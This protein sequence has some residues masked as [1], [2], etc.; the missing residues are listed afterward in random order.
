[1]WSDTAVFD[2]TDITDGGQAGS[3][4]ALAMGL[5]AEAGSTGRMTKAK[6]ERLGACTE[7]I[8]QNLEHAPMLDVRC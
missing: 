4:L 5:A 6:G 2:F 1:M 3:W 7:D 8:T